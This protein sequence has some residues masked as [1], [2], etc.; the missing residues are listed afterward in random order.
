M[1]R[2]AGLN[3]VAI[4]V[5]AIAFY[6]VGMVIYGFALTEVWGQQTLINHGMAADQ[7]TSLKGEELMNALNQIP[8]A[9]GPAMA[10]GLGFGVVLLTTIGIAIVL[11]LD[12]PGYLFAALQTTFI[13]WLCFTAATLSYNVIYSSESQTIFGIDLLYHFL[14]YHIAA[15][16]L[17]VMD[18][19]AL[20]AKTES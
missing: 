7:A 18:S 20:A 14:G 2:V 16:V 19:K 15:A 10:Y 9:M 5:A 1:P 13:V 17:Y 12:R 3:I 8:G 11:R 6:A 4:L